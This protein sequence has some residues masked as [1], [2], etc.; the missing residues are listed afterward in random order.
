MRL[1]LRSDRGFTLI[2]LLIVVAIACI[3]AP[4][5]FL[6]LSHTADEQKMRHFAEEIRETISDTQMEAVLKSAP[7]KIVFNTQNGYY[8]VISASQV[9]TRTMDARIKVFSNVNT[10]SIMIN[11]AGKFLQPGTYTFFMGAIK[12]Q[13]VLQLGQGRFRIVMAAV[14]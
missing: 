3:I 9:T 6:S 1:K 2:E 4:I 11:A 5:S 14:I 12:Y 10:Q 8:Q 13:L 7:F